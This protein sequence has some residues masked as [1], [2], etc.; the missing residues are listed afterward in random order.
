V[1]VDLANLTCISPLG[2]QE[3]AHLESKDPVGTNADG[4]VHNKILPHWIMSNSQFAV[5]LL[6][7]VSDQ[8]FWSASDDSQIGLMHMVTAAI[9]N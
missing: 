5:P 3:S 9:S 2:F 8:W 1:L 7:W 6:Q 4:S